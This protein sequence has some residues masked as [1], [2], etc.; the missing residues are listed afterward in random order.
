MTSA[1]KLAL[2]LVLLPRRLVN[3]VRYSWYR[4]RYTIAPSFRFNGDDIE[5]YGEGTINLGAGSYIGALSTVQSVAGR[6]VSIGRSCKISHNVR[7]YSQSAVA[8]ADFSFEPIPQ[9]SGDIA[10]GNHVWIGVIVYIGPG[11]TIG[12]NAVIGAN[13]VVT[14]NVGPFEIWGG[15]PARL[16][17]RKRIGGEA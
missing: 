13:V 12:E 17:R 3:K 4:S 16:I 15:V 2:M 11:V 6:T 10:I 1:L 8:D 7:I 14:R 9:I 5:L